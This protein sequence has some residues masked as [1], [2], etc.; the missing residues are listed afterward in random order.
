MTRNFSNQTLVRIPVCASVMRIA[1]I[2]LA[3]L[4]ISANAAA[5]D[6][7]PA[8]GTIQGGFAIHQSYDLGGH[9]ADYS[10]SD[11]IYDTLVNLQSGPRILNQ[12]LEMHAVGKTKFP[13]FDTL[14]TSSAGYGGDPDNF[15]FLQMSKANLYDFHG[16]FRRDRQYFDY[17]LLANPLVPAGVTSNGYT[18]PQVYNSPH[19]FNTVRR[20]TDTD[21]TLFPI[22]KVSFH[23]GYAQNVMEGPTYSS[24]HEGTEALLLQNWRNSTDTWT[25]GVNWKL[26][27]KTTLTLEEVITHYKGNTDWDLTGLNLQLSN[28]VPVTLGFDNVSLPSCGNHAA[29]IVDSTTTPATANATCNGYLQ[30]SRSQPTRTLFPTEEFRFQSSNIT[31]IQMNGRI[32]YTGANLN[33]PS[34][35]EFF[36]G[37]SSRG[38]E[39]VF[40]VTGNARAQRVNV[41]A[42]YGIVWQIAPRFALSEQYDFWDFRQPGI[43]TYNQITYTGTS[44]LLPPSTTG[45]PAVTSD[46]WFLGQKT[47]MNTLVARWQA[48]PRASFSLGY[49]YSYR[50]I[51]DRRPDTDVIP[52]HTQGGLLGVDLRPSH[53]WKINGNIEIAYADNAYTQISP[54]QLQRYQL[55][56]TYQ[57]KSWATIF[58]VF[59]D[60]ERRNN[61]TY[62][63]HLDHSRAFAAGADLT[64]NEHYGVELA[65]G[66]IDI[67]SQTDECYASTPAPEGA[68]PTLSPACIANGTPYFTNG[69]YDSPTQYGSFGFIFM[70]IK[71]LTS[72]LGYRMTA[73]N[74]TAATINP[75][76]VPGSL[77]SQYQSPYANVAWTVHP[78]WIWKGNWNY[79]GYGEGT[80][81]GPTLPRSFRGNVYTISMHYEF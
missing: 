76:Q 63:N 25:G 65:Y 17:N 55:L 10:G 39:R 12:S 19:L 58:G 68:V 36:N 43:D 70:P 67:F 18:F 21:L 62:V 57:P 28:G 9:I 81:I 44:M 51:V 29:P 32:R 24:I 66:Y 6:A 15:T 37:Y 16:L 31:N 59:N 4:L 42:D 22:S 20:M 54:R 30:Y 48:L 74:G 35:N 3:A 49:R 1:G 46:A 11:S 61:V 73:V 5:Q 23:A 80:P 52:I 8:K 50:D 2:G 27:T 45:T 79:Y 7:T 14:S 77:Q 72:G 40:T 34:L 60:L 64:P 53:N 56:T 78:G 71:Q 69:Y 75:L 26:F 13:L 41:S 38:G 47:E 33:L